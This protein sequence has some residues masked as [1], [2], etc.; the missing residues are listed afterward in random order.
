MKKIFGR[1]IK[2][3]DKLMKSESKKPI[4]TK[5]DASKM[6]QKPDS[7]TINSKTYEFDPDVIAYQK[8]NDEEANLLKDMILKARKADS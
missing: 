5:L 8:A 1:I 2:D 4:I 7:V 6:K 3:S